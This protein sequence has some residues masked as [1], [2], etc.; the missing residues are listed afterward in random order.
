MQI[1]KLSGNFYDIGLEYGRQISHKVNDTPLNFFLSLPDKILHQ[2]FK[3]STIY[4]LSI[5]V[6]NALTYTLKNKLTKESDELIRG[7]LDG[8]SENKTHF[9]KPKNLYNSFFFPDVYGMLLGYTFKTIKKGISVSIGCS[10]FSAWGEKTEDGRLITGRNFDFFG[11]VDWSKNH[12]ALYIEPKEGIPFLSIGSIGIPAFGITAINK[13]GL[14]LALHFMFTKS[15]KLV[16][17]GILDIALQIIH[18][19]RTTS[20]AIDI[21]K[22]YSFIAGW[23]LFISSAREKTAIIIENDAKKMSIA[24]PKDNYLTLSNTYI[25]EKMKDME[26]APSY[27]WYEHNISRYHRLK[28]YI[29][30]NEKKDINSFLSLLGDHYDS[31]THT[32]R[33]FGNTITTTKN[34]S[35]VLFIPEE[36]KVY[37]AIDIAPASNGNFV[38]I[39]IDE[40]KTISEIKFENPFK[41]KYPDKFQALKQYI[42]ELY[43]YEKTNNIK[44]LANKFTSIIE[45]DKEEPLYKI[46]Y[47]LILIKLHSYQKAIYYLQEASKKINTPY[48]KAL[49]FFLMGRGYDLLNNRI[50]AI[51]YYK[52]ALNSLPS[53]E[54]IIRKKAYKHIKKPYTPKDI[55]KLG[56]DFMLVDIYE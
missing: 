14:T 56:I 18:R 29:E 13:E 25:S 48:K 27:S 28:S 44:E 50:E 22:R 20:E 9:I 40:L 36:Q 10:S 51:K 7:F 42:L 16:G 47:A 52:N 43:K 11:E 23:N 26:F 33:A 37:M 17:N 8:I 30:K 2:F 49:I 6:R 15:V 12:T 32:E 54:T 38:L 4:K 19:A 39:S 21:A 34:A 41:K 24:Y 53:Q 1:I 45:K 55:S 3:N 31:F 35:S 46:I 5:I